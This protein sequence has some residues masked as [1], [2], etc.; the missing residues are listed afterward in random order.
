MDVVGVVHEVEAAVL[1]AVHVLN[2]LLVFPHQPV[3]GAVVSILGVGDG[4]VLRQHEVDVPLGNQLVLGGGGDAHG[5]HVQVGPLGRVVELQI[6]ILLIHG[7][8]VP[9]VVGGNG[10]GAVLHLVVDLI[11]D[12]ALHNAL[13]LLELLQRLPPVC[14]AVRIDVQSQ[15]VLRGTEGIARVVE[16]QDIAGVALVPEQLPAA[17]VGV[18]GIHHG[19]V[20]DDAH[21]AVHIRHGVQTALVIV[22]ELGV[23]SVEISVEIGKIRDV[24]V[25]QL[26]HQSLRNQPLDHIIRRHDHVVGNRPGGELGIHILV[27][28]KSGVIDAHVLTEGLVVPFLKGGV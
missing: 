14:L 28:G 2:V 26:L 19:R 21:H 13:L 3:G 4:G 6:L 1:D 27:A 18:V 24:F 5:I 22:V 15:Q 9:G 20:V 16:L 17:D 7:H 8:E 12:I 10:G 11:H 23:L 25:I